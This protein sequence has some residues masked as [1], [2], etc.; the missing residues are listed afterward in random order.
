[1]VVLIDCGRSSRLQCG[2]LDRL[3]Q[4]VNIAAKLSEYACL[5]ADRIASI[6]YAQQVLAKTAMAGGMNQLAQIRLLLGKL[7]ALNET[8]N[9]LNATLEI[10]QVLKRRGLVVFL[11]EIEQ[12]EASLQLLQAVKLLSAKHQ[13]LVA[14]LED[15]QLLVSLKAPAR[16]W[17]DPYQQFAGLEYKRGR[18]LTRQQLRALGVD[19]SSGTATDLD[20][21]ILL[22][23]HNQR[24]RISAA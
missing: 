23:Y 17:K 20:E 12:P 4:Y 8:A 18:E 13:V 2:N 6:A 5:H 9:A 19:I 24:D 3:H 10:K 14:N 11:T 7:S 15:P 1:M 16:T 21:K 22:Y